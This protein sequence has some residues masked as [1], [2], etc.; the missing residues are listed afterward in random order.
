MQVTGIQP[1][2]GYSNNLYNM[3]KKNIPAAN[4]SFTG[5]GIS[6]GYDNLTEWIARNYFVK[7]YNSKFA[8][9]FVEKTQGKKWDNMTTH[10]AAL[11]S[12]LIS[13]MYVFRTLTNE[14]LDEKKRKTLAINDA[15]T[16][17]VS[18]AGMYFADKKLGNWWENVTTRFAANYAQDNP[19]IK[20]ERSLG[21]WDPAEIKNVMK[22]WHE[23]VNARIDKINEKIESPDYKGARKPLKHVEPVEFKSIRDFNLDV[24]KNRKLTTFIDG[25]GVLKSLF[26]FG[27]I[28]RYIVPVL[29]MKPANYIGRKMHEKHDAQQPQQPKVNEEVKK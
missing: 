22:N 1:A 25:M 14:K 28:Y 7:F 11:G 17:G 15:L 10:M 5:S 12:T 3:N 2:N 23:A 21:N 27:M 4:Q 20:R 8:K 9:K 29:V 18:T 24:L 26:I 6:K 13:G 16:W 19:G